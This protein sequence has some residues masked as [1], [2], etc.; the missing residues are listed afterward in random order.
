M[1]DSLSLPLSLFVSLSLS[2]SLSLSP[3]LTQT[4]QCFAHLLDSLSRQTTS[5]NEARETT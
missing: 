1:F 4:D 3:S 2:L 5:V